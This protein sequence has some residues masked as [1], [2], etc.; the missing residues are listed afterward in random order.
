ML[1]ALYDWEVLPH[2]AYSTDLSPPDYD[3][4]Q[5]LKESL[6]GIRFDDQDD[7]KAEVV[8][9]VRLLN[10]SCLATGISVHPNRIGN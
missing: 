10:F 6:R 5:K 2:P 9:Q 1:V 4:F 8:A 7:L 3:L